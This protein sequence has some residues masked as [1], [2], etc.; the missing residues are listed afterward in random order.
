[1]RRATEYRGYTLEWSSRAGYWAVY[2]G[3]ARVSV[4]HT[5]KAKAQEWVD[6]HLGRM[7]RASCAYST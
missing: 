3:D 5:G 1:M 6:D 7:D 2:K 4:G